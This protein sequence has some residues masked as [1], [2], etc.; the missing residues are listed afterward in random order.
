M[1]TTYTETYRTMEIIQ[2]AKKGRCMDNLEQYHICCSQGQ[3]KQM[4]EVLFDLKNRIFEVYNH[5]TNQ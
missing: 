3:N 2:T 1:H 5:Y 4:T